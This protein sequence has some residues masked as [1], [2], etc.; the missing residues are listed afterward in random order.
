MLP[1][2]FRR[3]FLVEGLDF[4]SKITSV[5]RFCEACQ[6]HRPLRE[7]DLSS[8]HPVATCFSCVRA[9]TSDA[10]PA[11]REQLAALERQRRSLI[12]TLVKLDAEIADLRTRASRPSAPPPPPTTAESNGVLDGEGSELGFS[13]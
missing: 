13:D 2:I 3:F 11:R 5:T 10:A 12:A 8:E 7:F 4:G 1:T 6:R 9:R